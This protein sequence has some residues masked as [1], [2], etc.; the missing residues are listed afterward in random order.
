MPQIGMFAC[1][2]KCIKCCK[3]SS[4]PDRHRY[5]QT[6]AQPGREI[7]RTTE[8]SQ[9]EKTGREGKE[10]DRQAGRQTGRQK[11]T[12]THTRTICTHTQE[13]FGT[14]RA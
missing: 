13:E 2:I 3:A 4:V 1:S 11:C 8:D 5:R 10:S 7:D 12:C 9:R 6:Q 14:V